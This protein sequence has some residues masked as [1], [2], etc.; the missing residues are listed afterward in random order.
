MVSQLSANYISKEEERPESLL[1]LSP[2]HEGTW[3]E[4]DHL[5]TRKK[6]LTR[7]QKCCAT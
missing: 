6:A 2:G 1:S 5:P 7:G 4:G 3:L